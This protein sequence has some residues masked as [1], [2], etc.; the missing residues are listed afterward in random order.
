MQLD[1]NQR[2]VVVTGGTGALGAAVVALLVDAGA[3]CHVPTIDGADAAR[4]RAREMDMAGRDRVRL[5]E[6]I[7]LRDEGAVRRLYDHAAAA[8]SDAGGRLW[9]SIHIAG[10]FDMGAIE[11]VSAESWRA[12]MELNAT[13]CFLCCRE[14]VRSMRVTGGVGG[15]G[16]GG[17]IVNVAARPALR[18]EQ[19]ARMV[20]Y[21]AS[22]AAVAA[23]TS[24]LAAEVAS[25]RILVNAVAPSIMDTPANRAAMPDADHAGWPKVDEV[26][27]AMLWLA[28]PENALTSGTV[29][30]VYGRG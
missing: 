4:F 10:G 12:M 30:P 7:D 26:A 17:R 22:K 1:F 11:G 28:S 23:I 18:P 27:A 8:A 15:R 2:H 14:A 5:V 24:S 29:L 25:D 20:A 13:S 3:V 19:G 9:A 21:T 16:V 6:G